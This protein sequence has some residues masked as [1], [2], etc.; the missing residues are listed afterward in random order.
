[1]YLTRYTDPEAV[2]YLVAE[3]VRCGKPG[4]SCATG[5]RHGP[6]WYLV[7]RCLEGG[8]WRQRKRYVPPDLEP[9]VRQH[10]EEAKARD[11]SATALLARSRQL[12]A[13]V[14][15]GLSP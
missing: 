5:R 8:A 14:R 9:A 12:R 3:H 10:L 6:Y 13:A 1:M 4:C 15:K 11:R 7:Y 2:G